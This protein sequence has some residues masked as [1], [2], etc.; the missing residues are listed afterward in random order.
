[1][2]EITMWMWIGF[3]LAAYS[4]IANDSIQTLGTWNIRNLDCK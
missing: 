1:M 2:N 4:V 3:M